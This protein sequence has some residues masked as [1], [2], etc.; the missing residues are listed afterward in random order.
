M[1]SSTPDT[2]S[3]LLNWF[4]QIKSHLRVPLYVNAYYLI[5]NQA[6]NAS[7]GVV[8]W[9]VAANF[10]PADVVGQNV[11]ILSSIGL[12]GALAE[13]SLK[14]AV[15]RFVPRT[16][17]HTRRFVLVVYGI[18]LIAVLVVCA[19]F[20]LAHRIAVHRQLPLTGE[21]LA[22]ASLGLG[23]L[24]L[25]TS[26]QLIFYIQDGVLVAL[27][28]ARWV[29]IE[30]SVF[31]VAKLALLIPALHISSRYG[32][33]L[34][35]YLP[36]PLLIIAANSLIF[37][38]FIPNKD[39][40]AEAP[41]PV[42]TVDEVVRTVGGDYLGT[43]IAEV[44]V[45]VLPLLVIAILGSKENAYFYQ[46]WLIS[47]TL[48]AVI[49]GIMSSFTV[50]A[51]VSPQRIPGLSRKIMRQTGLLVVPVAAFVWFAADAILFFFGKDYTAAVPL[52]RWLAA[53]ILPTIPNVWFLAYGRVTGRILPVIVSQTIITAV[54]LSSSY[55]LLP[56]FGITAVGIAWFAAQLITAIYVAS[57]A[58]P[59]LLSSNDYAGTKD[60]TM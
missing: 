46:A 60:L 56:Y 27:R 22:A 44:G 39:S 12:L 20:Y 58:L 48:T 35:W 34:S 54:A 5:A 40:W 51:S 36:I 41:G 33:V 50:E 16:G 3:R 13:L 52:L 7:I 55:L 53:A 45:R 14:A 15:T 37:L 4:T 23:W 11:A 9:I 59:I 25:T 21:L 19:L 26:C 42:P 1:G 30:N 43:S 17:K 2:D 28:Q 49:S 38:K 18:N 10:Y 24:I 31:G 8:Y 6:A 32:I 29:L 47:F 57:R